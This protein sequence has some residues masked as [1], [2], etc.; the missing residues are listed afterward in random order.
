MKQTKLKAKPA[1]MRFAGIMSGPSDLSQRK[2]FSL[3]VERKTR[4]KDKSDK[5][6]SSAKQL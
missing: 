4:G 6:I 2:G 1:F 5:S 3:T